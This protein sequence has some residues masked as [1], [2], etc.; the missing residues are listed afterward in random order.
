MV[1]QQWMGERRH[2][3]G[4]PLPWLFL[5]QQGKRLSR[6]RFYQLL[7]RYG[8]R[9]NLPLP[10]HP[11]MLRHA[12]GYNLAERGNDTRLIQDYLGHRNIRHTVIYTAANAARFNNIWLQDVVAVFSSP[13]AADDV[14]R[15]TLREASAG[16]IIGQEWG[17]LH[18]G[19]HTPPHMPM[20]PGGLKGL[21]NAVAV[22][23][24]ITYGWAG[25]LK[26]ALLAS[27]VTVWRVVEG[28]QVIASTL[29]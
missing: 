7:R 13:L 23:R 29:R 20:R 12:C 16:G 5:S 2:Y 22:L 11:H 9:A 8:H 1:L 10:L 4:N 17:A 26:Q 24:G 14:L 25:L 18:Y 3:P 28:I 19:A 6:Q 15:N 21:S 27:T